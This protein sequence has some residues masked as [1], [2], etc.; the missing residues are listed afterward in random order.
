MPNISQLIPDSKQKSMPDKVAT[1]TQCH[2]SRRM[3]WPTEMS[4]EVGSSLFA[5]GAFSHKKQA[6]TLTELLVVMAIISIL[7]AL[8]LSTLP[9]VLG[10]ARRAAC[11]SSIRQVAAA[12]LIGASDHDRYPLTNLNPH[13]Y[14]SRFHIA[15]YWEGVPTGMQKLIDQGYMNLNLIKCPAMDIPQV[16]STWNEPDNRIV[17]TSYEYRFN[18]CGVTFTDGGT[19][20]QEWLGGVIYQRMDRHTPTEALCAEA[21]AVRASNVTYLPL[22]KTDLSGGY[23]GRRTA[24]DY[25][26][27]HMGQP[28][29]RWAHETGGHVGRFDG[30]VTWLPNWIA[31]SGGRITSNWPTHYNRCDWRRYEHYARVDWGIDYFLEKNDGT[32]H[33]VP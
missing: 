32:I 24:D 3:R 26:A 4:Y 18:A 23:A 27:P 7:A 12:A 10:T 29:S 6:F 20:R 1:T 25:M 2:S 9:K 33:L 21:A 8:L 30:S 17:F 5:L 19:G 11:V 22:A 16:I 13:C 28:P 31:L 15:G 14:L